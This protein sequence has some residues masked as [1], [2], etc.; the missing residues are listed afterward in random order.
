MNSKQII[1][2]SLILVGVILGF[3]VSDEQFSEPM[4][5]EILL[6]VTPIAFIFFVAFMAF[7]IILCGKRL[8]SY[9]YWFVLLSTIF[10]AGCGLGMVF[11]S[12]YLGQ[13]SATYF[14]TLAGALGYLLGFPVIQKVARWR[15]GSAF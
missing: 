6:F 3:F 11:Q 12:L 8:T 14:F 9:F 15:Y 4:P 2:V 10:G 1:Y 7:A 5:W 13:L